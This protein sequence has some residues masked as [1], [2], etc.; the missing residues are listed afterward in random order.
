VI[1]GAVALATAA[2]ME[3]W[4]EWVHRRVW[5]GALWGW[6]RSHHHKHHDRFEW[7]D[8]LSAAHAPVAMAAIFTGIA[9][10]GTLFGSLVLG[11]GL[12]MTAFGVAYMTV[13]D[14]FVHGRLPVGFLERS[15]YFRWVRD[16]HLVHH[17]G[18]H[19]PYGL[20]WPTGM[21][22]RAE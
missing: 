1:T 13:H 11:V 20:F 18:N 16:S 4:A 6:H 7:N 15:S 14:G 5:H 9:L 2:V 17:R 12:G 22:D 10:E 21:P 19:G 3:P 8:V